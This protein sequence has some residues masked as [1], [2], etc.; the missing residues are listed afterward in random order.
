MLQERSPA[1]STA[2]DNAIRLACAANVMTYYVG[3]MF[4]LAYRYGRQSGSRAFAAGMTFLFLNMFGPV[5]LVICA[6]ILERP[7]RDKPAAK[8]TREHA[9]FGP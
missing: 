2:Q 3:G 5:V 6:H 7:L 8:A 9:R 1:L 4:W